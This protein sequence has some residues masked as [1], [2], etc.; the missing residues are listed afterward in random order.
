MRQK[1]RREEG[2][3]IYEKRGYTVEPVFGEKVG[4]QEAINGLA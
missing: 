1:L 2:K 4:W 3:R